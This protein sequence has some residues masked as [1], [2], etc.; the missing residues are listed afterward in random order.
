MQRLWLGIY[1]PQWLIGP[2]VTSVTIC[3]VARASSLPPQPQPQPASAI[4]ITTSPEYGGDEEEVNVSLDAVET[5][6]VTAQLTPS[7]PPPP[8]PVGEGEEPAS[9]IGVPQLETPLEEPQTSVS[10]LSDVRPGDWAYEALRSLVERYGVISGYADGTFR[11]NRALSRYEFAATLN[12]TLEKVEALIAREVGGRFI[13]QD[14]IT[15]RRLEE[16]FGPALADVRDRINTFTAKTDQMEANQ[17][18]TTTKLQGQVVTAVTDGNQAGATFVSRTRLTLLTSFRKDLLVTQL[19]AGNN[20]G[21]TISRVHNQRQNL[22]GTTGLLADGGGFD[23]VE[24]PPDLT[25]RRLYY[26]FSPRA[27]VVVT[28]GAKMLPRD[29]I[30]RSQYASDEATN[31]SSSFFLHNPLIIQNQIDRDGGA[32]AALS[33]SPGSGKFTVRSLYI[34]ADANSANLTNDRGGLF[35]DRYQGSLEFEYLPRRNLV[36]RL[37]YTNAKINNTQINAY[38]INAEYT[39]NRTTAAF[40]RLG[41]GSYTGFNTALNRD[42]ELYPKTWAVGVTLRNFFIPGT[43]AGAAI[44]QPFITNDLG[45]ANQWNFETFYNLQL[46]DNISVTPTLSVVTNANNESSNGTAWQASLRTVFS[47]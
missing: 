32:G 27:D 18:S 42:L 47:F 36:L 13:E 25:V 34:A 40:G 19:E 43:L 44:G 46:S 30:D 45:N 16:E 31:F 5:S 28:L 1:L 33:W 20:G 39:F 4:A 8:P 15:L 22:L 35:S 37:Q 26:T 24:V 21:D 23:Y 10:Q 9:D 17:F 14:V 29:F 2:L 41:F 11:G 7:I 3:S 12:A 38:G 6:S